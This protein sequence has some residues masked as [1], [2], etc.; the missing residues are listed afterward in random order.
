MSGES[1][2]V[3]LARVDER[4]KQIF[5]MMEEI[6]ED[7]KAHRV[8]TTKMDQFLTVLDN[9]MKSMETSFSKAS[10]TID[11]F[12]TIKHKV[13][14]AGVAGKWIWAAGASIITFLFSARESIISWITK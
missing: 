12:I 4:L 3:Q 7:Q 9:R 11:E 10:P 1:V 13:Q 6:N 2:E 5:Q 14:G 8:N